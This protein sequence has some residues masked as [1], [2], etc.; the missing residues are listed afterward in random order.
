MTIYLRKSYEK[1][2]H[3]SLFNDIIRM[4]FNMVVQQLAEVHGFVREFTRDY[5][6]TTKKPVK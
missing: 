5:G 4:N 6:A 2:L 1:P 3:Y